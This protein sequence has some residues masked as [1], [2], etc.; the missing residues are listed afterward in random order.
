MKL[1][2]IPSPLSL[3]SENKLYLLRCPT[4]HPARH[5]KGE[6]LSYPV[7]MVARRRAEKP[8]LLNCERL[9]LSKM[10]K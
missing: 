7:D 4:L 9:C 6:E 3:A 2:Q 8:R 10:E 1:V 5:V